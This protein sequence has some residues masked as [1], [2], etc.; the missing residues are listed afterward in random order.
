LKDKILSFS[1]KEPFQLVAE[2][3]QPREN[4]TTFSRQEIEKNPPASPENFCG[5]KTTPTFGRGCSTLPKLEDFCVWWC[6]YTTARTFFKVK[7]NV[8]N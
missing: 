5:E 6:L 8:F 4:F 3:D 2:G 1:W 7:F